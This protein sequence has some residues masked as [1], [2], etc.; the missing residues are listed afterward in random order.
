VLAGG[1][2]VIWVRG[3]EQEAVHQA[4]AARKAQKQVADQLDEVRA[5]EKARAEAEAQRADAEAQAQAEGKRA[6]KAAKEAEAASGDA[7]L[8]RAELE[9]TNQDLTRARDEALKASAQER[10]LRERVEK[11]LVQERQRNDAAAHQRSKI[12]TDLR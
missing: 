2:A 8:S 7:K 10:A 4:E 1:V 9:R 5:Q 11:L 3:A 6:Q 12:T